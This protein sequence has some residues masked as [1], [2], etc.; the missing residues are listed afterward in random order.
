MHTPD[1]TAAVSTR[2]IPRVRPGR[3]TAS[4]RLEPDDL[5][6]SL[7]NWEDIENAVDSGETPAP[8]RSREAVDDIAASLAYTLESTLDTPNIHIHTAKRELRLR[9]LLG[10]AGAPSRI[11]AQRG[12]LALHAASDPRA[13]GTLSYTVQWRKLL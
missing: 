8:G 5:E 6:G 1:I 10:A 3:L 11:P 12:V 2:R 4:P 13:L 9:D 7:Y